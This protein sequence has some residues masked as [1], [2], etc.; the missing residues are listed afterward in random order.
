[1]I[2]FAIP[3]NVKDEALVDARRRQLTDAAVQLFARQGYHPTTVRDIA[4]AAGVSVGSVYTYFPSKDQILESAAEQVAVAFSQRFASFEEETRTAQPAQRI[5]GAFSLLVQ[6]VDQSSDL[7][8]IV[9]RESA[10][11]EWSARA[12]ITTFEL[13][14][15][16][17]FEDL[18]EQGVASG[19]FRPHDTRL[20]AQTALFLAHMWAL[21]RWW[22]VRHMPHQAYAEAQVQMLLGDIFATEGRLD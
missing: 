1:M 22:L 15:R 10:T 17:V 4:L 12:R 16:K 18:L 3:T 2:G 6:M 21:K 8:L 19:A 20:R 13:T 9:Y 14:M 5:A 7:H 11:L